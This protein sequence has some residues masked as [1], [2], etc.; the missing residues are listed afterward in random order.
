M[1]EHQEAM[2]LANITITNLQDRVDKLER[3]LIDSDLELKVY[4]K[5]LELA[6]ERVKYFEQQQ[7]REMGVIEFFGQEID[8]DLQ[9]I[10]SQYKEQAKEILKNE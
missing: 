4:K 1:Q 6:C 3:A 9:A 10:I 8:Y 2:E 5:A 7:D